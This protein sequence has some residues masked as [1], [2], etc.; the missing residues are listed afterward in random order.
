MGKLREAV[1]ANLDYTYKEKVKKNL[2]KIP[3]YNGK[4]F[5]YPFSE[6]LALFLQV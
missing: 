2:S 4:R 1:T 3:K 6:A 5:V